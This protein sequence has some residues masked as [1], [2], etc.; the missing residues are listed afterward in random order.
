[1]EGVL[2]R[3]GI[4]PASERGV[5]APTPMRYGT[6]G[7]EP[8][9]A[10]LEYALGLRSRM[11]VPSEA[12]ARPRDKKR[13]KALTV[14]VAGVLFALAFVPYNTE[15]KEI[16]VT[17]GAS[18]TTSVTIPQAGWV[19][20]HFDHPSGTAMRQWMEGSGGML[21]DHSMM[22]KSDSYSFWTWGGTYECGAAFEGSGAGTM[23]VWGNAS[24][25]ML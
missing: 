16:H 4:R 23:P 24:R 18:A 19:T 15:S 17:S 2:Q 12:G 20:V 11:S 7:S 22:E 14:I 3:L 6:L 5:L 21:H 8:I 1:M 9:D 13:S 10:P 25:G